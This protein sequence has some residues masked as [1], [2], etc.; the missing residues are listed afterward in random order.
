MTAALIEADEEWSARRMIAP[1]SLTHAWK[2]GER[3]V[4]TEEEVRD[5]RGAARKAIGQA[6]D[7]GAVEA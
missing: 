4:P 1:S 5:A 2:P 3:R 7:P 6:I